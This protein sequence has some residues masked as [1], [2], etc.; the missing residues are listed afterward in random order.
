MKDKLCARQTSNFHGQDR[1]SRQVAIVLDDVFGA[2]TNSTSALD[3]ERLHSQ[4]P[5]SFHYVED[6]EVGF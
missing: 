6:K 3:L 1:C 4:Y 2:L 5:A